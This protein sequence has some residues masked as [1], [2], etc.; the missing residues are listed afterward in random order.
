[1]KYTILISLFAVAASSQSYAALSLVSTFN[2]NT[3]IVD[4]TGTALTAG[5][6]ADGDGA[7]YQIGYFS[8]DTA[9]FTGTWIALT[10]DDSANPTLISSIG[11]SGDGSDGLLTQSFGFDDVTHNSLPAAGTQLALRFYNATSV[12]GS[13]HYNTVTNAAWTLNSFSDSPSPPQALDVDESSGRVWQDSSNTFKT[14]IVI[15]PEPSSIALLGLGLVSFTLR[16][17]R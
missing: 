13:T 14:S 9:G 5:I 1:M 15:V 7:I 10:G 3:P 6:A 2:L 4:N 12:A 16:R 11:D 17:R 8:V